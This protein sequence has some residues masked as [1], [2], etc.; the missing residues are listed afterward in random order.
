MKLQSV[1]DRISDEQLRPTRTVV[2]IF[3]APS[4]GSWG[5]GRGERTVQGER[6]RKVAIHTHFYLFGRRPRTWFQRFRILLFLSWALPWYLMVRSRRKTLLRVVKIPGLGFGGLPRHLAGQDRTW[7][8]LVRTC[9]RRMISLL[10]ISFRLV[11]IVNKYN[12]MF[13]NSFF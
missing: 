3:R 6:L 8:M 11:K 4:G 9:S 1:G 10:E 2:D 12:S 7:R 5:K 13:H